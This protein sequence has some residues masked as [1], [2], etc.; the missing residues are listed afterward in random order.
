V[1]IAVGSLAYLVKLSVTEGTAPGIVLGYAVWVNLGWGV[2]NLLPILPL[3]GGKI[4]GSF[5]D[6]LAPQKGMR[7]AHIVS[8]VLAVALGLLGLWVGAIPVV[9]FCALFAFVNIQALR[10]P[11]PEELP[12][13]ESPG[14][15]RPPDGTRGPD[16]RP[17]SRW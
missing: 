10:P 12:G 7:A 8:I 5:F 13:P 4:M 16:D 17:P 2:L 15:Q 9:V 6:L 1:G 14:E 3:D 11:V